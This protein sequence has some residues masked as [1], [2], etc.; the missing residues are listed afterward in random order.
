MPDNL[1]YIEVAGEFVPGVTSNITTTA[2]TKANADAMKAVIEKAGG[3]V[4]YG[5]K[6]TTF[7]KENSHSETSGGISVI[8]ENESGIKAPKPDTAGP[9]FTQFS[10]KTSAVS[11]GESIKIEFKASDDTHVG[12]FNASFSSVDDPNKKINIKAQNKENTDSLSDHFDFFINSNNVYEVSVPL[13]IDGELKGGKYKLDSFSASD[14]KTTKNPS[15][16]NET[17]Y[18]SSVTNADNA[19]FFKDLSNTDLLIT[20]PVLESNPGL[21]VINE[22]ES[23]AT[24]QLANPI[25]P[26]NLVKGTVFPNG[27]DWFKFDVSSAGTIVAQLDMGSRS[28][29]LKL[30]G[31]DKKEIVSEEIVKSG[32]I[33]HRA[34][35]L[36]EYY[37]LVTDGN[38]NNSAYEL[39][40]DI[41]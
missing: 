2:L 38:I 3:A 19:K 14:A 26:D 34:S 36:G 27:E 22:K 24:L 13:L 10:V 1:L 9:I 15:I 31:P 23:N 11:L 37:I 12:Y 28:A 4:L 32:M 18:G 20:I 41:V 35:D 7:G 39:V 17:K 25:L 33:H 6:E 16:N 29:D 8:N 5:E 40:L 30:Y 21:P